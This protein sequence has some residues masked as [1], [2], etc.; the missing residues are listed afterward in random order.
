MRSGRVGGRTF[1]SAAS[2]LGVVLSNFVQGR[3]S[4]LIKRDSYDRR[5]RDDFSSIVILGI[6]VCV[7]RNL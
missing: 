6:T 2:G 3:R 4:D 5:Y 7:Y 1:L